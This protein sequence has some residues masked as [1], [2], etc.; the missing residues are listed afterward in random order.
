M[1]PQYGV[2]SLVKTVDGGG[3]QTSL[4]CE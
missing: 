4:R 2:R 1:L 3:Y